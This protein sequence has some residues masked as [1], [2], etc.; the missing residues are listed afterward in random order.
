MDWPSSG[1]YRNHGDGFF[2]AAFPD[3]SWDFKVNQSIFETIGPSCF[4]LNVINT[5][6]FLAYGVLGY[7][8]WSNRNWFWWTW[9]EGRKESKRGREDMECLRVWRLRNQAFKRAGAEGI[10]TASSRN[11]QFSSSDLHLRNYLYDDLTP[12]HFH[13]PKRKSSCPSLTRGG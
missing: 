12:N 4:L 13:V 7:M 3:N 1:I 10:W 11:R 2:Y 5:T 9:A 6:G 8:A